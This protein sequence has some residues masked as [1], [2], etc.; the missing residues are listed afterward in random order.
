[1]NRSTGLLLFLPLF[2]LLES[3]CSSPSERKPLEQTWKDGPQPICTAPPPDVVLKGA[4]ANAD[5]AAAKIGPLLKGTGGVSVDTDR[6]RMEVPPDVAAFEVIDYR[7]CLQYG[8][9]VISKEEYL[10]FTK[11]VLPAIKKQTPDNPI[12]SV[13]VAFQPSLLTCQESIAGLRRQPKIFVPAWRSVL[14]RLHNERITYDLRNLFEV[15]GRIPV[16]LT[17]KDLIH[18]AIY[19]LNCLEKTGELRMDKLK[20]PS[21]YW[22]E[23]F[24]NQS[25][26][27]PTPSISNSNIWRRLTD[28]DRTQL[29]LILSN[30]NRYKIEIFRIPTPDSIRLANDFYDFFTEMEWMIPHK[31][32]TPRDYEPWPGIRVKSIGD[33]I[34]SA[35]IK[36]IRD[37]S[38]ALLLVEALEKIKLPVMFETRGGMVDDLT[39]HLEI[40]MKPERN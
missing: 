33:N 19:T 16:G 2:L 21:T 39:I 23:N 26:S 25:I 18:E 15:W 36:N 34:Q 7:L 27:F 12:S 14:E 5:L 28:S 37:R 35:Q 13:G 4:S 3:S 20:T 6:I 24:E 11:Q 38:G 1:M 40:G 32:Q 9:Q 31:P 8:N 10:S 30:G 17:G 29:S 22:G